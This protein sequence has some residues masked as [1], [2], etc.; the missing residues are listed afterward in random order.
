MR[1]RFHSL[2]PY[3]AMFPESF[4]NRHLSKCPKN[5]VVFDPFCGRGTTVFQAL[6][7]DHA[8]GGTDISP[9]AACI[10]RAK[11]D[12]PN[13]AD[14]VARLKELEA[15]YARF[16]GTSDKTRRS[17]FF[18]WCFN[19]ETYEQLIFLRSRLLWRDNSVDCFIA[20]L[21]LWSLHGESHRSP[22]YFSNRMPRTISTKPEYSIQWWRRNRS[23]PPQRNVF[24]I[25]TR[26]ARL[27]YKSTPPPLRAKIVE[28][29]ARKAGEAFPELVGRV[30]LVITSPPYL[31][32]TNYQ[33]DQWLRLWFLGGAPHPRIEKFRD[34]RHT[35][36]ER[37]WG[38]LTECWSGIA[39]LLGP[40]AK[41]VVRIGGKY[42]RL[43]SVREKLH[44]TLK[45]GFNRRVT[46]L[47]HEMSEIRGG[48]R[49]SFHSTS[50]GLTREF[51]FTFAVR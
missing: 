6:L 8:A 35:S 24:E 23:R 36:P 43:A 21:A 28:T 18:R 19:A 22:N 25:L 46:L 47:N 29:D 42:L 49:R 39:P 34:D 33:E 26:M 50:R 31:D 40:R 1:H 10:S 20:A 41:I 48:Q 32:V 38:F 2:C 7:E 12:A 37:Y 51:D 3:F 17:E 4:V 27:R 9:V 15:T 14:L 30:S 5:S 45:V 44:D 11:A 16:R 13:F